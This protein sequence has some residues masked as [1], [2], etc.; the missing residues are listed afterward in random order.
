MKF[1]WKLLL[2]FYLPLH[3][4]FGSFYLSD[5]KPAT[6]INQGTITES[7]YSFEAC[8]AS[9]N[10]FSSS[11]FFAF[12]GWGLILLSVLLPALILKRE[13]ETTSIES[14]FNFEKFEK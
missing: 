10:N 3:F 9:V 12:A 13:T 4:A 14:I 5:S 1:H 11:D 2:A 6:Q 7:G 8:G